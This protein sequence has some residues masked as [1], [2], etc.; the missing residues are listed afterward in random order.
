MKISRYQLLTPLGAGLDGVA[1]RAET[2][3]DGQPLEHVELRV[4]NGERDGAERW[5]RLTRRLKLAAHLRHPG[6]VGVREIDLHHEPP[7][8]ALEWLD[9][10][11][12]ADRARAGPPPWPT[13]AVLELA[14]QLADQLTAAHRLGLAHVG[15][16][17]S[18]IRGAPPRLD[19]TGT[20][21]TTPAA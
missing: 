16:C 21:V 7:F 11:S 12:L 2:E 14:H 6:A 10:D 13:A 17:P 1:Y 15:L 5:Q 18:A 3:G 4:L 20:E 8:V 9:A 19:F